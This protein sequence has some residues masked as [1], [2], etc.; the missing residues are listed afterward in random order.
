MWRVLRLK[1]SPSKC[2]RCKGC[3]KACELGLEPMEGRFGLECNNCGQCVRA[4]PAD[5][6]VWRLGARPAGG[7]DIIE[8]PDG[9]EEA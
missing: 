5:A 3:N 1:M 9:L 6:L 2:T 4:C 8:E 7:R